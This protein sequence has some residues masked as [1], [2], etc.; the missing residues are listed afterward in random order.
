MSIVSQVVDAVVEHAERH[1]A[2]RVVGVELVVGDLHDVVDELME[3]CFQFLARDT[4]A[5]GARLTLRKVPVRMRCEDCGLV[6]P[7]NLAR[8]E[9][10][11]CPE[12]GSGSFGIFSGNEFAI[13]SIE[14]V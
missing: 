11:V 12:C 1:G 5:K 10:L 2:E 6:Y 9:T 4:V 3:S 14:I 13:Q 8:K 7:A